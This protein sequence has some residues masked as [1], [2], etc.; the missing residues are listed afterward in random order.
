[1]PFKSLSVHRFGDAG[2][3]LQ[4]TLEKESSVKSGLR[5]TVEVVDPLRG[6]SGCQKYGRASPH[7]SPKD[8]RRLTHGV[9]SGPYGNGE[10]AKGGKWRSS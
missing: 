9:E 10:W 3:S 6:S 5:R 8:L 2:Q 7:P 4:L 1:M